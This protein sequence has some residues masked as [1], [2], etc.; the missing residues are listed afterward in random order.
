MYPHCENI[1][2]VYKVFCDINI[3]R[4]NSNTHIIFSI[5]LK[6][7]RCLTYKPNA[8]LLHLQYFFTFLSLFLFL[9]KLCHC[10]YIEGTVLKLVWKRRLYKT[11]KAVNYCVILIISSI[12]IAFNLMQGVS[13]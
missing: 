9:F 1:L 5:I 7:S 2:L 10:L 11:W 4:Q 12:S 8:F 3:I 6:L 13:N